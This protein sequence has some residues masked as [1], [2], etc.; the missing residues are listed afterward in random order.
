[1]GMMS[2]FEV[3]L[4]LDTV[5]SLMERMGFLDRKM[6]WCPGRNSRTGQGATEPF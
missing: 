4:A 6:A 5:E 1:M 2:L 3:F